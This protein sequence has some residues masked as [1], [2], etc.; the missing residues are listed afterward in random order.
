MQIFESVKIR[1]GVAIHIGLHY[2]QTFHCNSKYPLDDIDIM[3]WD[4]EVLSI[5]TRNNRIIITTK[6]E[7]KN[8]NENQKRISESRFNFWK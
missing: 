6:G 2:S 4:E 7:S 1:G 3:Y 5:I 8:E